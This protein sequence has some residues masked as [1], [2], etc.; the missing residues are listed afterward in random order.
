M[1]NLSRRN[2][3]LGLGFGAQLRPRVR[4]PGARGASRPGGAR[5]HAWLGP[6]ATPTTTRVW[7]RCWSRPGGAQVHV[8]LGPKATPTATQV[9]IRCW[10]RPGG[11]QAHAWLGPR[12]LRSVR[13]CL[14]TLTIEPVRFAGWLADSPVG[15]RIRRS[16]RGFAGWL[17]DSDG[18]QQARGVVLPESERLFGSVPADPGC[19]CRQQSA[20]DH[21][22]TPPSA[23]KGSTPPRMP[24]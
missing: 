9:W 4:K 23:T 6:E 2:R 21:D 10:S 14:T 24:D 18:G 16:V 3:G 11:A 17:A 19:S 7:I 13:G 15:S 20:P 12:A 5:A 22:F 8:W 1:Q